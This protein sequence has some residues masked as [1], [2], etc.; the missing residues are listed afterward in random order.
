VREFEL[1][2]LPS[3]DRTSHQVLLQQQGPQEGEFVPQSASRNSAE[4]SGRASCPS[5]SESIEA[6]LDQQLI[7]G[8]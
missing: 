8:R 5:R 7:A 6:D 4:L 2:A 3:R 1:M